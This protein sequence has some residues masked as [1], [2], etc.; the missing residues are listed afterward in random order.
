MQCKRLSDSGRE[1][2]W[3]EFVEG[4]NNGPGVVSDDDTNTRVVSIVCC[5]PIYVNFVKTWWGRRPM[6]PNRGM[7]GVIVWAGGSEVYLRLLCYLPSLSCRTTCIIVYV[8]VPISPNSL[9]N[10]VEKVQING[11]PFLK[12]LGGDT[13]EVM[14][15]RREVHGAII[16]TSPGFLCMVAME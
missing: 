7:R 11:R 15:W 4:S 12:E 6:G 14:S 10:H 8:I 3:E 9:G 5:C 16:P 13:N 2:R 1:S